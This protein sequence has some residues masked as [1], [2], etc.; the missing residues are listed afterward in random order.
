MVICC[1]HVKHSYALRVT[2]RLAVKKITIFL[3]FDRTMIHFQRR[4]LL[5]GGG[6]SG[7]SKL[8]SGTLLVVK[9]TDG[10]GSQS[11]HQ[12]STVVGSRGVSKTEH[13]LCNLSVELGVGVSKV[14]LNV[15][16]FLDVVESSVHLNH[17]AIISKD[18][19]L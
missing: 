17:G 14:G 3:I 13:G 12:T 6:G 15:N 8:S 9:L 4:Q 10:E 18:T 1:V 7:G 5:G 11:L 16:K 19:F 2:S